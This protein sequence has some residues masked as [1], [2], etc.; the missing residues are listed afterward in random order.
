MNQSTIS[1]LYT[2]QMYKFIWCIISLVSQD[3]IFL[4]CKTL[5]LNWSFSKY[6]FSGLSYYSIEPT[7]VKINLIGLSDESTL[8]IQKI[9]K[10]SVVLLFC[11]LGFILNH[12]DYKIF[13]T[14]HPHWPALVTVHH[15]NSLNWSVNVDQKYNDFFVVLVKMQFWSF[16]RKVDWS[17]WFQIFYVSS[18]VHL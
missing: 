1:M 12:A 15:M 13:Q 16:I 8:L 3:I 17:I 4:I 11:F 18:G 6:W 14:L 9:S 10:F 5:V 2:V 7:L